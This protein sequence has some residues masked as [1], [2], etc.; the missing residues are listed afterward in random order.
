MTWKQVGEM[1]LDEVYQEKEH[2]EH[3]FEGC[4]EIEQGI[5]TKETVRYRLCCERI[6]QATGKP[7][8]RWS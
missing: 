6:E 2:L 3:Y 7:V 5:N 4:R 8:A 1:T